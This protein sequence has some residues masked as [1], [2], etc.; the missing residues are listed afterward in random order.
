MT[1]EMI[2]GKE[3]AAHI[4]EEL[5][6]KIAKLAKA[7]KLAVILAGHDKASELYVKTNKRLP[8]R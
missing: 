3:I 7:P 6:E 8:P 2:N 5:K 4:R 1:A